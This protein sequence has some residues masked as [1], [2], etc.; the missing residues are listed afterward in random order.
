MVLH[1]AVPRYVIKVRNVSCGLDL[2]PEVILVSLNFTGFEV[3][4]IELSDT[5]WFN[6]PAIRLLAFLG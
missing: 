1:F 4:R 3:I 5:S 6:V 2:A